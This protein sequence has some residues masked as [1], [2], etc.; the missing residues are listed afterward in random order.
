MLVQLIKELCLLLLWR[1]LALKPGEA[2]KGKGRRRIGFKGKHSPSFETLQ[3]VATWALALFLLSVSVPHSIEVIHRYEKGS[4]QFRELKSV[5]LAI[6]IE[7]I[8]A[9]VLLIGLHTTKLTQKQRR[10]L[11]GLATPFVLLTL[12]LQ[13]VYYAGL[14]EWLVYPWELAAV[15]PG[16]VL[17]CAIVVAFLWPTVRPLAQQ[18]HTPPQLRVQPIAAATTGTE[19]RPIDQRA[20][21]GQGQT[22]PD[23]EPPLSYMV[24]QL[25]RQ[26]PLLA[27]QVEALNSKVLDLSET[28]GAVAVKVVNIPSTAANVSASADGS[29][30]ATTPIAA[31]IAAK[32]ETAVQPQP[33]TANVTEK[34]HSPQDNLSS[35]AAQP[36]PVRTENTL[37]TELLSDKE[38]AE[39]DTAVSFETQAAT[40]LRPTQE[41]AGE[42]AE[43]LRLHQLAVTSPSKS[44]EGAADGGSEP[45]L[46]RGSAVSNAVEITPVQLEKGGAVLSAVETEEVSSMGKGEGEAETEI[47]LMELDLDGWLSQAELSRG[48]VLEGLAALDIKSAAAAFSAL[49]FKYGSKLPQLSETSFE[50]LYRELVAQ[51]EPELA[52]L[53]VPPAELLLEM[54]N[55]ERDCWAYRM[56]VNGWT[57]TKIANAFGKTSDNSGKTYVRT[58]AERFGLPLR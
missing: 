58:H 56:R 43:L 35:V 11:F 41:S 50:K 19:A 39:A 47:P 17:V 55:V 45:Q 46:E 18:S 32:V 57:Y 49:K 29:A 16:G 15:L 5:L 23:T 53:V 34:L 52:G 28:V 33:T 7:V 30:T 40:E 31:M 12:H 25:A 20:T 21:P 38:L 1:E 6:T 8:A 4:D 9:L 26:L 44:W 13:F 3:L 24:A 2:G 54:G 37:L 36:Q 22:L 42:I 48:K 10:T 14:E 51:V 27:G